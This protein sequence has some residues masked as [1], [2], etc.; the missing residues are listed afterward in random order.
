M[1]TPTIP[2]GDVAAV[3]ALFAFT[4]MLQTQTQSN[5]P[6]K[7]QLLTHPEFGTIRM[8]GTPDKPLFCFADVTRALD[9]TETTVRSKID[10]VDRCLLTVSTKGGFQRLGFFNERALQQIISRSRNPR[11][12]IL[13]DWLMKYAIPAFRGERVELPTPPPSDNLE[14]LIVACLR[15]VLNNF[16]QGST[17]PAHVSTE[18]VELLLDEP[19]DEYTLDSIADELNTDEYTLR[20]LLHR[21]QLLR[22]SYSAYIPRPEFSEGY[23]VQPSINRP[24]DIDRD[25]ITVTAKGRNLIKA[26]YNIYGKSIQR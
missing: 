1:R 16:L 10:P 14:D 22:K 15:K 23:F 2:L 6:G 17:Q 20:V 13:Y 7:A 9:T 19:K 25:P 26:V 12:P 24:I 18:P 8:A 5:L 11:A 21:R 3:R 4:F